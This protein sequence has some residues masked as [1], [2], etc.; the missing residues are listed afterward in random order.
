MDRVREG[1]L[2]AVLIAGPTASGKSAL[3][4]LLAEMLG[5]TVVNADSMQVYADLRVLSARPSTAEEAQVPHRM[6]GFVPAS[7][8]YSVG[9]YLRDSAAVLADLRAAGRV[10]IIVGGTGLY[11]RALT[12]GLVAT[13]DIPDALGARVAALAA[14]GG[15]LRA[16]L[17]ARDPA[18]A[19]RLS[20]ADM[21]RLMRALAVVEATGRPLAEWQASAQGAPLLVP[22][23]W[24]GLFINPDREVLA[25]RINQR[26]L[27]MMD[28]GALDEVRH[29]A[30]L[31]LPANRGVMK[32]HGVPHLLAHL[33]GEM[34][35]EQAI[36]RG[37]G[38]TRRYA[39]RQMTWARKFMTGWTWVHD[40]REIAT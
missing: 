34:R 36:E 35:L 5:G 18:A 13:P 8:E 21:P 37:Q 32:A 7:A 25:K 17:M 3:A 40:A 38:D 27:T 30:G 29:L 28:Q 23:R 4:I 19:A 16:A 9:D 2:D 22:G 39:K 31:G 15:D 10:P 20:P 11:F 26:F 1:A 12:E 24:A 33:A 14:G 6:F